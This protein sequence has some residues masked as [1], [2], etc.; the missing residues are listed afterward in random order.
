M[1]F[2]FLDIDGVINPDGK[3]NAFQ[4]VWG[5]KKFETHDDY[6]V[7]ASKKLG[8]TLLAL[9]TQ[10]VWATTWAKDENAQALAELEEAFG[11]PQLPK[12]DFD[13]NPGDEL[14]DSGKGPAIKAYLAA[15]PT[16]RWAWVDD[17]LSKTDRELAESLFGASYLFKPA[18]GRG[19]LPDDIDRI[20]AFF[21][22]D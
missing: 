16:D 8:Q 4:R 18:S 21:R 15:N 3:A 17:H 13:G 9:P 6:R 19:L 11:L 1:S 5:A 20:D 7:W 12:I 2:L 22:L 10:I 14:R